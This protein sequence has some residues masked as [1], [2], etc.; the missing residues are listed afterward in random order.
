[1][2]ALHGSANMIFRI[3]VTVFFF[4]FALLLGILN[5]MRGLYALSIFQPPLIPSDPAA[6]ISSDHGHERSR[7]SA[8]NPAKVNRV[9][10]EA[11]VIPRG[12]PKA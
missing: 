6:M 8:A 3:L 2:F 1:M 12:E 11:R 9:L 7:V 10:R 4:G 5:V